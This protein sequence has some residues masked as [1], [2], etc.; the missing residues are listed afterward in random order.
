MNLNVEIVET[1]RDIDMYLNDEDVITISYY[2]NCNRGNES[3]PGITFKELFRL[4]QDNK[5]VKR[6]SN[7][8]SEAAIEIKGLR[9]N[10]KL[11]RNELEIIKSTI[12]IIKKD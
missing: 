8:L 11:L 5:N 10:N 2:D 12:N 3:T 7:D 1:G 4:I 9:D 6:L